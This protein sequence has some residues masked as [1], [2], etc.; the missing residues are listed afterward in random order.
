MVVEA[1]WGPPR[2]RRLALQAQGLLHHQLPARL[3]EGYF[4]TG[5]HVLDAAQQHQSQ[6]PGRA[7][8]DI[9][10]P[11]AHDRY[12]EYPAHA[13]VSHQLISLSKQR[14]DL[15]KTRPSAMRQVP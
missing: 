13:E 15:S 3:H 4:E 11:A 6:N 10:S 2:P 8:S 9:R 5:N 7:H 12:A 1:D 14:I